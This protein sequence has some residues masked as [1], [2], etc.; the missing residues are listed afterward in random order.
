MIKNVSHSLLPPKKFNFGEKKLKMEN[1]KV[2]L[3]TSP[4][5]ILFLTWFEIIISDKREVFYDMKEHAIQPCEM[6][7]KEITHLSKA[8]IN[9][10]RSKVCADINIHFWVMLN[11]ACNV[12]FFWKQFLAKRTGRSSRSWRNKKMF[13]I[14]FF[15]HKS[16][17]NSQNTKYANNSEYAKQHKQ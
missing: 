15:Q 13:G 7:I 1:A 2:R 10:L 16:S 17:F 14:K 9:N 11:S 8:T 6:A 5:E 4:S 3:N 12:Y